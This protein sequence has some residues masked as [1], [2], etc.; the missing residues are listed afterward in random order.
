ML[1]STYPLAGHDV[2][3]IGFGAMQLPGPGVFGPP[4]DHDQAIAVL[5]R[6]VELGVDHIDT[7][8]FY[9]PD[10]SNELIREALHPYGDDLVLVS[11]VGARRDAAGAWLPALQPQQLKEDVEENLRTLGT[12]QLGAVNLRLHEDDGSVHDAE[13]QDDLAA[14]LEAMKQLRDEGKIA[15]IGIS[16]A[17]LDQVRTAHESVGLVCVQNAFSYVDQ[18]DADVLDYCTEQGIAYVPYFPLGSA[19]PQM[20]KVTDDDQVKAVAQRLG[21]TPAQVGLAW[22]LR[23]AANVLLIPGTSSVAHLED[24]IATGD[25]ELAE[26]DLA[27]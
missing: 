2:H 13:P 16:T 24:N 15:G 21:V 8:Q 5:R 20:P 26:G 9:G 17:T 3:R 6:A 14:Q 22:L 27:G 11:K 12:E 19:F 4:R 1:K 10:V 7:A 18:S 25:V 23:R